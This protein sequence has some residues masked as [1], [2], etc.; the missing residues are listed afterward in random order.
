MNRIWVGGATII[1]ALT[2]PV[3]GSFVLD[4]SHLYVNIGRKTLEALPDAHINHYQQNFFSLNGDLNLSIPNYGLFVSFELTSTGQV[5]ESRRDYYRKTAVSEYRL[6]LRRYIDMGNRWGLYYGLGLATVRYYHHHISQGETQTI[7]DGGA[8]G[9]YGEIAGLIRINEGVHLAA[10][11]DYS[12]GG[13]KLNGVRQYRV[14][15]IRTL[16]GIGFSF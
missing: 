10:K 12:K 11:V 7:Y 6:G 5:V 8:V 2:M 14:G 3:S 4:Q 13:V 1:I 16:F 15:G 9:A